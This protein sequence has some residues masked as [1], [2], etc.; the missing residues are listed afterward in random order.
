[1]D[2]QCSLCG[3]MKPESAFQKKTRRCRLCTKAVWEANQV[4][5]GHDPD[6]IRRD[7]K[8]IGRALARKGLKHDT[9]EWYANAERAVERE[10]HY[11]QQMA[12]QN[13]LCAISRQAES[14]LLNGKVVALARDHAS[15]S[16]K[17]RGLLTHGCNT[18]LGYF[19]ENTVLLEKAALYLERYSAVPPEQRTPYSVHKRYPTQGLMC[20]I[21]CE[22]ETR[23]V[24]GEA[25][26][27][28]Q[29]HDAATN[30]LRGVLCHACNVGLGQFGDSPELLRRA[31][32]YLLRWGREPGVSCMGGPARLTN[33]P[34]KRAGVPPTL[35][36]TDYTRRGHPH[37]E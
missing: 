11:A 16:G 26:R 30:T 36:R 24:R 34:P 33:P 7:K 3:E 1:M 10:K 32:E 4:A 15:D 28:C 17:W 5:A 8:N 35:R 6:Q 12:E 23:T 31:A 27:P 14:K 20:E 2:K 25:M 9:T 22:P 18:G 37:Y 13:G 19:R 29:D 21:C